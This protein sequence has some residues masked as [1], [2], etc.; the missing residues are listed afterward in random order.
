MY[1]TTTRL[2]IVWLSRLL[3]FFCCG[4]VLRFQPSQHKLVWLKG[5]L[6]SAILG[7]STTPQIYLFQLPTHTQFLILSALFTFFITQTPYS[8]SGELHVG[9]RFQPYENAAIFNLSGTHETPSLGV[10]K[11]HRLGSGVLAN[12][13]TLEV[14]GRDVGRTWS[15]LAATV[16][17]GGQTLTLSDDV[18]WEVGGSVWVTSTDYESDHSEVMEIAQ[19]D[20][21]VVTLTTPL[22]FTHLGETSD[23]F[24]LRGEVGYLS[25]NI[26]FTNLGRETFGEGSY[27][28]HVMFGELSND[29]QFSGRGAISFAEFSHCGQWGGD[30]GA[31]F[32]DR[33][34]RNTVTLDGISVWNSN[35][36]AVKV[37]KL[38]GDARF[39]MTNSVVYRSRA[40]TV[41]IYNDWR[42][43]DNKVS[44]CLLPLVWVS[45]KTGSPPY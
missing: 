35:S 2:S 42:D 17:A 1:I 14:H 44:V 19:I 8:Q 3:P 9:D 45:F 5:M 10:S 31:F 7:S 33:P 40:T 6:F 36:N 43:G 4:W 30:R 21:R 26:R 34:T 38:S 25:R 37:L 41:Q 18:M 16:T 11:S 29:A 15:K 12:F 24:E 22:E 32:L 23:G 28:C 27:G 20:G 39:S 13:G